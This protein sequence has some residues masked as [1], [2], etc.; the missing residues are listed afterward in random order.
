VITINKSYFIISLDTELSWGPTTVKNLIFLK[1]NGPKVRK[2]I[3]YLLKLFNENN[4]AATW[5]VVGHL[6]LEEC[7]KEKCITWKNINEFGYKKEWYLDPYSNLKKS[8]LFYGKD[9]VETILNSK[10]EQEIGYHSYSHPR[11]IE[12]PKEMAEIEIKQSKQIEKQWNIKLK[13]FVFPRNEIAYVDILKK[14]DF[15]IYRG[16]NAGIY[17]PEESN[18]VMRK[19]KAGIS[20]ILA[21]PVEAEWKNGIWEIKGSMFFCD[22]QIP[23]SIIP[24]AKIGLNQAILNKKVFHIWLHPWNLLLYPKLKKDLK[25][26]LEYVSKKRKDGKIDVVTM[27]ELAELLNHNR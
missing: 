3:N 13:S 9:I 27:V 8:P 2:T 12:I 22:P 6:F 5:A 21:S 4:I 17:N 23:Q 26:F 19:M 15:K 10:I 1:Q 24:K 14:Y 7:E 25:I 18:I 16:K 20:K 11:F